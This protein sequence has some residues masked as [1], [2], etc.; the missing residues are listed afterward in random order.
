M[1]KGYEYQS[2]FAR[3]YYGQGLEK[4]REVGRELGLQQAILVLAAT[5]L[6]AVPAAL[7]DKLRSVSDAAALSRVIAALGQAR[8]EVEALEAL[9]AV[10]GPLT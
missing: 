1:I 10:V 3:K 7:E 6:T 5:R 4:G 8:N 2:D 9:E